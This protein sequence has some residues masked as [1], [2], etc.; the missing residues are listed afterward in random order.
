[1]ITFLIT[2][3]IIRVIFIIMMKKCCFTTNRATRVF[4][5]LFRCWSIRSKLVITLTAKV[6]L[7]TIFI[8]AIT[9][10]RF[11]IIAFWTINW[12]NFLHEDFI[13]SG[14]YLFSSKNIVPQR[15]GVLNFHLSLQSEKIN[16]EVL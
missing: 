8:F 3:M 16:E 1:M 10:K 9:I 6:L 14:R 7:I 5:F 4:R 15:V 13:L 12:Y 11:F 2:T